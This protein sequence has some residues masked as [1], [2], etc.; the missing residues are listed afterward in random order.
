ML[1]ERTIQWFCTEEQLAANQD[2][3]APFGLTKLEEKAFDEWETA[4]EVD[5]DCPRPDLGQV[6]L[7]EYWDATINGSSWSNGKACYNWKHPVCP[8]ES[9]AEYNYNYD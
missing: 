7:K 4:C 1:E 3:D 6:C 5:E 2:Q 8:G 9:F